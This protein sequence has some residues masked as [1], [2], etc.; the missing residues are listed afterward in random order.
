MLT[1]G[2]LNGFTT[3]EVAFGTGTSSK[4]VSFIIVLFCF[5]LIRHKEHTFELWCTRNAKLILSNCKSGNCAN[6]GK[7]IK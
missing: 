4:C 3:T 7:K 5:F 2:P 1:N 6:Q